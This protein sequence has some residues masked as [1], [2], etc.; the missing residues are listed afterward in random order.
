MLSYEKVVFSPRMFFL[1]PILIKIIIRNNIFI[2]NEVF[3]VREMMKNNIL[4]SIH[5]SSAKNVVSPEKQKFYPIYKWSSKISSVQV[6]QEEENYWSRPLLTRFFEKQVSQFEQK[7]ADLTLV[8]FEVL[9]NVVFL[10]KKLDLVLFET[11]YM[12]I[13][14]KNVYV[15]TLFVLSPKRIFNKKWLYNDKLEKWIITPLRS[16]RVPGYSIVSKYCRMVD[17]RIVKNSTIKYHTYDIEKQIAFIESNLNTN[18][19][20]VPLSEEYYKCM[21]LSFYTMTTQI[22]LN[23]YKI[24][25]KINKII[26]L[27]TLNLSKLSNFSNYLSLALVPYE[28]KNLALVSTSLP[29]HFNDLPMFEF[30]LDVFKDFEKALEI[31]ISYKLTLSSINTDRGYIINTNVFDSSVYP[32][33]SSVIKMFISESEFS[34]LNNFHK[35]NLYKWSINILLINMHKTCLNMLNRLSLVDLRL[36]NLNDSNNLKVLVSK[37]KVLSNWSYSMLD[38]SIKQHL[39]RRNPVL[40]SDII[41]GFDT[42]YVAYDVG[43]NEMLSAQISSTYLMK[44]SIPLF[45]SFTFEGVNTL[46]SDTYLKATP[47]FSLVSLAQDFITRQ[48][49]EIRIIKFKSHDYFMNKIASYFSNKEINLSVTQ[50]SVDFSFDKVSIKNV[51]VIPSSSSSL[52]LSFA[53]LVFLAKRRL[54]EKRISSE[55]FIFEQ[56]QNLDYSNE[57][58]QNFVPRTSESWNADSLIQDEIE[59]IALSPKAS[60]RLSLKLSNEKKEISN[61]RKKFSVVENFSVEK[62]PE[63]KSYALEESSPSI[64]GELGGWNPVTSVT[65]PE[66]DE[67]LFNVKR[68]V[69]IAAHYNAADLTLISDWKDVSLRNLD[70][71]KKCYTSLS[72]PLKYSGGEKVYLRDTILL[73]SAAAKSLG[74]LAYAY[75]MEKKEISDFYKS[76]M[77]LLFK[78]DFEK[79]KSYAMNDSLITLIHTLFINDF[80]FK[81]GSLSIPNTLGTL[82]S[83]YIKNKWREDKYRGYQIDINYPLGDVRQSHTPKGIQFGSSTVEMSNLFIG[84]LRGGRNECFRYGIDRSKKWFD[85]D[86]A[87]CYSTIMSMMGQPEY[88]N[89]ESERIAALAENIMPMMGQPEYAKAMWIHPKQDLKKLNLKDSYSAFKIKFCLPKQI[90]YPPFPVTLDES[91]TIYPS[92]GITLV[93]GA[94]LRTGIRM[95]NSTL[96]LFSLSPKD[97]YIEVLYGSYIPF[98]KTY[99]P[100]TKENALAYSPFFD[101]IKELQANRSMWK[102]KTGKGSAMERIYK[103][104]GNMLYGKIVCGISNKKVYDSRKE[105]MKTMIGNDLSNPILGTWITGFVRSLIAELLHK[106]DLLGGQVLSCTTDGFVCDIENLEDKIVE[107]FDTKDSLL[108]S[109]RNVRSTLSGNEASLEVK[110]SVKGMIQWST[111][112]QLSLENIPDSYGNLI[113]ISA[114]TGYQKVRNHDEN[115]SV[116]EYA[117]KNKNKVLFLQKQLTGALDLYKTSS[118]VSMISSQRTFRTIFDSK[119]KVIKSSETMLYTE[120]FNEISEA[121]LH[122]GLMNSLKTSV[123]SSEFSTKLVETSKNSVDEVKKYFMRMINILYDYKIPTE[124]RITIATLLG[125]EEANLNIMATQEL[126]KGN[127]VTKLPIYIVSSDYVYDLAKQIRDLSLKNVVWSRIYKEFLIFFDNFECLKELQDNFECLKELQ[128]NVK[129]RE[130][131]IKEISSLM[132]SKEYIINK[133]KDKIIIEIIK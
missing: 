125:S 63:E 94:E 57:F 53:S 21:V 99:D 131:D 110:T 95:L 105:E 13:V 38:N 28:A 116:I 8:W 42:E 102:N 11:Y 127:I 128:D 56:I 114:A 82:S 22:F 81:L 60:R 41:S 121:L 77:D 109:Y 115:I 90:K 65:N 62:S 4:N 14:I 122:R 117:M 19:S 5:K 32:L 74:A 91:I 29:K 48:I 43:K 2:E 30:V 44:L 25:E 34:K 49:L 27:I 76:R 46:T 40:Y 132:S 72:I 104:L 112:G 86:L 71:V 23:K 120:P 50:R 58:I 113:P 101:V 15:E 103:D 92:S 84:S 54:S 118:H 64:K 3:A 67:I 51:F 36:A 87:S 61:F 33:V 35:I 124:T 55:K 37:I 12:W 129:T 31:L 111:R 107:N 80:S 7:L 1:A 24:F 106:V 17:G 45:K 20:L 93:T 47:K 96:D 89:T 26:D 68:R 98:K 6:H 123:Y 9:S 66:R 18:V 75:K 126:D 85:Y 39:L 52:S 97:F 100:E 108:E 78:N 10:S 16:F 88:E 70:I 130:I 133:T 69:Y 59:T 119:R 83:K 73:A 79:F